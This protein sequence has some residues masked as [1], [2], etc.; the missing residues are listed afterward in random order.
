MPLYGVQGIV[1]RR[2]E[3]RLIFGPAYFQGKEAVGKLEAEEPCGDERMKKAGWRT[4]ANQLSATRGTR[5][6]SVG[7]SWL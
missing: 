6:G 2:A 7:M 5:Q 3:S 1:E 4:L